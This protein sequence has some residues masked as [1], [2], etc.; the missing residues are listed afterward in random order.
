MNI[1]ICHKI[2]RVENGYIVDARSPYNKLVFSELADV[3]KVIAAAAAL[4]DDEHKALPDNLRRIADMLEKDPLAK[5]GT[6][7]EEP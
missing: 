6:G 2:E 7:A 4:G 1:V 5:Y 3:L